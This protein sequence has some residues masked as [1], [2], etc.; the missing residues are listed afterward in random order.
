MT[1]ALDF[2]HRNPAIRPQDDLFR[3]VNGA[4]LDTVVIDSDKTAEGGFSDL[5]DQAERDVRAIV[6]SLSADEA[7]TEAGKIAI[8]YRDFMDA[9]R[10][11]ELGAAP[12]NPVLARIEAIDG[13]EALSRHLGWSL[14]HGLSSLV[15]LE[16]ES[17]PGNPERY[18]LFAG[19]GGLGLPNEEYYRLDEH[20]AIRD[21]YLAFLTRNFDLIGSPDAAAEAATVLALE[22]KI[23]SHH[24]DKVRCRDL[25]AQ[26]N[27]MSYDEL[28]ASAPGLDW[29]A[30]RDGGELPAEKLATVVVQQP[31]FTTGAAEL[32]TSEPLENWKSWARAKAVSGL[33]AYLSSAFV[34]NRFDF[35]EKTLGGAQEQR[36]RWKRGVLF[37]EGVMGEAVGKIYVER[38]FQPEA[39]AAMDTLVANLLKAYANSIAKLSWMSEATRAEALDKLSKFRPKIGYPE[40][41]RT[42]DDLAVVP[43]DLVASVLA[44]NAFDADYSLSKV[45]GPVDPDEWL[46]YP[47][48]VNA[49]Y[50]PLRNEIVFP[51][52]ILQPPFFNTEADAA[53]NYGAIGAVIGHEIGHGFDD[54]G[55]T[56][57]GDGRL[58]DWWT[59][60]DRAAF[61][62]LTAGLIKQFEV[63]SP[64][65][66]D[67]QTIN[68]Q[69][70][71]GENIGDL[72][73][74]GIA[75]DAWLLAG[76]DPDGEPI[77][78]LTPAQRFFY[79]WGQ[80]WRTKRRPESA[81]M[82]LAVD[83]HSPAE[84]RCNQIVRNLDAFHA[85][86][87]TT[88]GDAL[89]LPKEERIT[90]W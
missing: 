65:G 23:A 89:W 15:G 37:V 44:S 22:T 43:G 67:G 13:V 39:K 32:L 30:Y 82:L 18:V 27:P 80:A 35:Y 29:E 59:E 87:G 14:R 34:T 90:I 17:D 63:L 40:K 8:L 16:E 9:E 1:D 66:T 55:S 2:S 12:L 57:D 70:T 48:T 78:E 49:Y 6:E 45:G 86:F 47:Q 20:A 58:R 61:E 11:E 51:A 72:G 84:F 31:S 50:H 74:L 73:G 7:T 38:H 3:H 36:P 52:A 62:Q 56:C 10:I 46:M 5:R 71:L 68:G 81:K 41:W 60:D 26:Y 88:D 64:E 53:V 79:G 24:W 76:G 69:L 75:Y 83:P 77:D 4:W 21:A 28:A 33:G 25:R 54:K 85:A 42:F 19:Q